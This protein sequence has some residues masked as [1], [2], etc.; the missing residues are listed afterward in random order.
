MRNRRGASRIAPNLSTI[1]KCL[2]PVLLAAFAGLSI[3][4]TLE[5]VNGKK[6]LTGRDEPQ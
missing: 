4:L 3:D 5:N 2:F 1:E 6:K